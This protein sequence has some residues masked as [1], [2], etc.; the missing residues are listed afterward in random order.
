MSEDIATQGGPANLGTPSANSNAGQGE[1]VIA[2]HD[3][4]MEEDSGYRAAALAVDTGPATTGKSNDSD[5]PTSL[6]AD[7]PE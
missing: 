6:S 5:E 7:H 2:Q 1:G 4:R 3:R